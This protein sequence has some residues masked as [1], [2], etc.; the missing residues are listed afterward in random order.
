[1]E[2]FKPD[3]I[4]AVDHVGEEG[5]T[6]T[7]T[8]YIHAAY[9]NIYVNSHLL[10]RKPFR[11]GGSYTISMNRVIEIRELPAVSLVIYHYSMAMKAEGSV[12]NEPRD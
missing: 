2:L 10:E 7:T 1:M 6:W 9:G 11:D 4:Y 3:R 12:E 5:E 8:G